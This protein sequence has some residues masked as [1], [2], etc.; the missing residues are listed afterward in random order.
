MSRAMQSARGASA[1]TQPD[2]SFLSLTAKGGPVYSRAEDDL[3]RAWMELIDALLR[4]LMLEDD[5]DGEGTEAPHPSLVVAAIKL[6]QNLAAGGF[7]PAER[8]IASVNGTIYFEWY[9][10][11]GYEEIEVLSPLDAEYRWVPKGSNE[12]TVVGLP[13]RP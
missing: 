6:A 13:L 7:P 4:S 9:T 12:T 2:R 10:P 11:L 5:W 3:G 1:F 8:V